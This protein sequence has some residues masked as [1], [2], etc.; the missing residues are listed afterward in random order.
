MADHRYWPETKKRYSFCRCE[1]ENESAL[2]DP[3]PRENTVFALLPKTGEENAAFP[4]YAACIVGILDEPIFSHLAFLVLWYNKIGYKNSRQAYSLKIK[5]THKQ[6]KSSSVII[7]AVGSDFMQ[8]K[9]NKSCFSS[10]ILTTPKEAWTNCAFDV[11]A[12][13][14]PELMFLW[15]DKKDG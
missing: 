7:L 14:V 12:Q 6:P 1:T 5:Y 13:I 10:H 11:M 15:V 9:N 8:E 4:F 2:T 3:Q